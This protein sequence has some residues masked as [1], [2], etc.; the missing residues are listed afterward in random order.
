MAPTLGPLRLAAALVVVSVGAIGFAPAGVASGSGPQGGFGTPLPD[1]WELCVLQGVGAPP[2]SDNVANLD[3]WQTAEGGSTNNTAA[4]NPFNT[5][6][7]TDSK[8]APIP[9]T[10]MSGGFPAFSDW[11]SGCAATAATI[12][13]SNMDPVMTSLKAGDIA[14]PGVFLAEV[15]R[16]AW[17]APS[18]DGVP[19]YASEILAGELLGT[20]LKGGSGQLTDALASYSGAGTDLSAY[21]K[22]AAATAVD[23]AVVAASSQQ[24]AAVENEVAVARQ[25][26]ATATKALR[27]VAVDDYTNDGLVTSNSHLQLFTP[28]DQE[29]AFAQ[30]LGDVA[31]STLA[32]GYSR[33]QQTVKAAASQQQA[34]VTAVTQAS[35][36]FA[37]AVT[38]QN[39][40]LAQLES[41]VAAIEVARS[42]TAPPVVTTAATPSATPAT[43]AA[44]TP[45]TAPKAPP[46]PAPAAQ[47]PA[48]PPSTP[49]ATSP[50]PPAGASSTQA[51]AP[52]V[53][54]GQLWTQLQTC[55][56]PSPPPGL[57][58]TGP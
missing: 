35:A 4:Y 51:P 24:L 37:A 38:A 46:A 55:L 30:Y 18:A 26:L 2:T 6:R 39:Q 45:T 20:L 7:V 11:P 17:C 40:A 31:V 8:N 42:C 58:T 32:D 50:G 47:G 16:S 34:A 57:P 15:D 36:A 53:N 13:Q 44:S 22:A 33:A 49:G 19:C 25:E 29:G 12:L 43:Q 5:R 41:D 10:T 48:A 27:R 54:A 1:G 56:A 28:T 21:E 23:E 3:E 9:G 52:S 14:P